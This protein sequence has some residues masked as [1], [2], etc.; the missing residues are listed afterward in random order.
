MSRLMFSG[1][2]SL[3]ITGSGTPVRADDA[4]DKAVAFV[5][6]LGGKFS[7]N[8]KL[9]GV[10][11]IKVDL[12]G[13][14][15]TEAGVK[16]L[17]K[18][19]SLTE[20]TVGRGVTDAGLKEIAKLTNLARL[21]LSGAWITDAGLKELTTLTKLTEL[22]LSYT[23]VTDT[24]M[25]D[26]AK[27]TNL[28]KLNLS[29]TKLTDAG[30]KDV[31]KLTNLIE[32]EVRRTGL[33]DA[34]LKEIAR[35]SNVTSLDLSFTKATVTGLEELAGLKSLAK[36]VLYDMKVEVTGAGLKQLRKALP[37]CEVLWNG[38][39]VGPRIDIDD[40]VIAFVMKLGGQFTLDEKL[41]G[42]RIIRVSFQGTEV[43]DA[44]RVHALRTR[45]AV[46][47]CG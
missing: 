27:L 22:D 34:G 45:D 33:T 1:V 31:A 21:D 42:S 46:R 15:V 8:E 9:P 16:E 5:N 2:V 35:L 26:L 12:G 29:D 23:S 47:V 24:G 7:R 38:G 6:K 41:A 14:K 25:K 20:L 17:A 30:L 11:V 39:V 40:K 4:E 13:L 28:T 18:L 10:P 43:T 32:L 36:L 37:N 3:L 19:S 44:G